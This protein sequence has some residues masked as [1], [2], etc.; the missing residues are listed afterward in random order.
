MR[1]M[2]KILPS[3]EFSLP[4]NHSKALVEMKTPVRYIHP[5]AL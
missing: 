1:E 2:E 5:P 3:S 4:Q